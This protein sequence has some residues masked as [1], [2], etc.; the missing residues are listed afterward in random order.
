MNEAR[1]FG[2]LL[3]A[4]RKAHN[5]GQAELAEKVGIGAKHLGRVERGEKLPSFEVIIALANAMGESPS[6]FFEFENARVD[7]RVVKERLRQL[8]EKRDLVQLRRAYRVLRAT[9]GP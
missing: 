9:L 3:R 6:V 2:Q 7:Q 8:L 5:M 1:W 4:T